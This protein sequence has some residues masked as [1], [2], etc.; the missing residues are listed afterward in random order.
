MLVY[1]YQ[2]V[3]VGCKIQNNAAFDHKAILK[4]GLFI[5]PLHMAPFSS[6]PWVT[7]CL[8][9]SRAQHKRHHFERRK[10]CA[11]SKSVIGP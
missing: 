9:S 10:I 11:L 7:I 1:G 4:Q 8:W 6:G 2:Q 3:A 5:L